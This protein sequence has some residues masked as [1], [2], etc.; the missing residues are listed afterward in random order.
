MPRSTRVMTNDPE[1]AHP[2]RAQTVII[3]LSVPNPSIP[4]RTSSIL[5]YQTNSVQLFLLPFNPW[6]LRMDFQLK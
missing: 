5:P 1:K 4:T 2:P 3:S 6:A